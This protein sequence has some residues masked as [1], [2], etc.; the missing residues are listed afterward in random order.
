[1]EGPLAFHRAASR[2]RKGEHAAE[3]ALTFLREILGA[4][5]SPSTRILPSPRQITF[6]WSMTIA[7][8]ASAAK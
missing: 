7:L 5:V 3:L 2:S 4:R 6:E 1:M 8:L